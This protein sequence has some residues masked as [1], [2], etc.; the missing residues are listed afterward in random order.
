MAV[1][2]QT[3]CWKA[4]G[5]FHGVNP[6][7]MQTIHDKVVRGE[8]QWGIVA[9]KELRKMDRQMQADFTEAATSWWYTRLQY[10][11]FRTKKGVIAHP[12]SIHWGNVYAHEFVPF[13]RI[14][15]YN[16]LEPDK[17]ATADV[18]KTESGRGSRSTWYKGRIIALQR[19]G[20]EKLGGTPFRFISRQ[21]QYGT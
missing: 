13:M 1:A 10:Y 6:T 21:Q 2:S 15:G 18:T 19:L 5:H 17:D 14:C 12:R 9:T 20:N 7:T 16:W 4:W 8:Q 3:L 11:E